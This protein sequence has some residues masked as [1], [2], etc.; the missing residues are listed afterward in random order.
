VRS[1]EYDDMTV[2]AYGD[3]AVVRGRLKVE[4]QDGDRTLS[5]T[6]RV[7]PVLRPAR[8]PLAGGRRP[9]LRDSFREEVSGGAQDRAAEAG[10]TEPPVGRP[11]PELTPLG[12]S[13]R[14]GTT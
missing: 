14:S 6:G 1:L 12:G 3:A 9:L 8:R 5:R 10:G 13:A 4:R 2:D 7:Y 11:T